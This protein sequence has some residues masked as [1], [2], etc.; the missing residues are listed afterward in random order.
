MKITFVYPAFENLGT[1]YLSAVLKR[2]G[3]ETELVLD[4]R[5]FDDTFVRHPVLAKLFSYKKQ[6]IRQILDS[7]P[8]LVAFSVISDNY[9]WA[10]NIARELK[11]IKDIPIVF[12][13]IHA[14][15]MPEIVIKNPFVDFVIAGEAEYALR[16]LVENIRKKRKSCN[17]ENIWWKNKGRIIK[18]P[19]RNL[20]PNLDEIP[21]AD[22]DLY[23][24]KFPYYL[25]RG[26]YTIMTSRGCIF[27]CTYC[28]NNLLKKIYKN[29]GR[30]TR[31]RSVDNV[32]EELKIAKS[33]YKSKAIIFHDETLAYDKEWLR[34]FA[35]KYRKEVNLPFF[36]WANASTIDEEVARLLS[37]AGCYEVQM[38]VQTI[39]E[40]TRK[41]ILNRYETNEQLVNAI[42]LLKKNNIW[43]TTDNMF[44][45]PGQTEEELL[46]LARFYNENRVGLICIYWLRYYPRTDIIDI[47]RKHGML[48]EKNV[49]KI[50][51]CKEAQAFIVGGDTYNRRFAQIQKLIYLSQILPKPLVRVIINKKLYRFIP[52][53]SS[54][55]IN[56][57]TS[58]LRSQFSRGKRRYTIFESYVRYT[59]F[60]PRILIQKL[61]EL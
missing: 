54:F 32:I 42:R 29:K 35:Q 39:S 57:F 48:D 15:S 55:G 21:F 44:G 2:A 6:V 9:K 1:E 26:I 49:K 41:E 30:Y 3:H 61:K 58:R 4:P 8:D 5:L 7:K 18:N 25:K 51:E 45:L 22:K 43:V 59:Y 23:Y 16:D 24:K 36:C 33:R 53:H 34:E 10:C 37:Y 60:M 20:I 27:N 11:N 12:G 50:E 28:N 38:G 46:D 47:S 31:R 52:F 13:G 56:S 40:K 19:V 17:I 14:T